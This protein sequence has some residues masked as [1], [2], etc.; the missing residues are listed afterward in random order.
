MS[1]LVAWHR[2]A[3]RSPRRSDRPSFPRPHRHSRGQ[4]RDGPLLRQRYRTG[5]PDPQRHDTSQM[6]DGLLP[7]NDVAEVRRAPYG[8]GLWPGP[9]R[10]PRWAGRGLRRSRVGPE[11][12]FCGAVRNDLQVPLT[13]G[14]ADPDN[15]RRSTRWLWHSPGDRRTRRDIDGVAVVLAGAAAGYGGDRR[16]P[17][18][19][20]AMRGSRRA[21]GLASEGRGEAA[22]PQR[23]DP[24]ANPGH[25]RRA[26]LA[27][28]SPRLLAPVPR[29][30]RLGPSGLARRRCALD[31]RS[32][33]SSSRRRDGSGSIRTRQDGQG[34]ERRCGTYV[35]RCTEHR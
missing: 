28:H 21:V 6:L 23:R 25:L 9:R 4:V 22:A 34:T 7:K 30:S 8:P 10:Q 29:Y 35:A 2:L 12:R 11:D 20:G 17:V 24:R 3:C 16:R 1:Q 32:A 19:G 27:A 13:T 15:A 5:W 14:G 26:T 31:E 33:A 18:T